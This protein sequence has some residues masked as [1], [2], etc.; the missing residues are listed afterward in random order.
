MSS[1]CSLLGSQ[2]F[3]LLKPHSVTLLLT[4]RQFLLALGTCLAFGSV[5]IN[6]EWPGGNKSH[7]FYQW[8]RMHNLIILGRDFNI[9]CDISTHLKESGWTALIE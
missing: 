9:A 8:E 2:V 7:H 1:S 6:T 5:V 4:D 3:P